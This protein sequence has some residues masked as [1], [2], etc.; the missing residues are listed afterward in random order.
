MTVKSEKIIVNTTVP[1]TTLSNHLQTTTRPP[2]VPQFEEEYFQNDQ[3]EMESPVLYR[4][5]KPA[6]TPSSSSGN[7]A[8]ESENSSLWSDEDQDESLFARS[9]AHQNHHRNNDNNRPVSLPQAHT[10]PRE[11]SP[12]PKYHSFLTVNNFYQSLFSLSRNALQHKLPSVITISSSG[13]KSGNGSSLTAVGG[14]DGNIGPLLIGEFGAANRSGYLLTP[15][16]DNSVRGKLY[17]VFVIMVISFVIF[18]FV[19]AV[20]GFCVLTTSIKE[21]YKY[22]VPKKVRVW[23]TVGQLIKGTRGSSSAEAGGDGGE[24]SKDSQEGSFYPRRLKEDP[25]EFD[26]DE[27]DDEDCTSV[28][29]T[30]EDSE[31]CDCAGESCSDT[32]K[33]INEGEESSVEL[34]AILDDEE[35]TS[36]SNHRFDDRENCENNN[37]SSYQTTLSGSSCTSSTMAAALSSLKKNFHQRKHHQQENNYHHPNCQHYHKR[38]SGKT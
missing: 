2:F 11:S 24:S 28:A 21:N 7:D 1:Q 8:P 10:Q 23:T 38:K 19:V 4:R 14:L 13:G 35:N 17:T 32:V 5:P 26:E 25:D 36:C 16:S 34:T 31:D 33:L 27:L 22:F 30:D 3:P 29:D 6:A 18:L 9:L 20:V 15:S 37:P 12:H